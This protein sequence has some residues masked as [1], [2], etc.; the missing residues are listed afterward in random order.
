MRDYPFSHTSAFKDAAVTEADYNKLSHTKVFG[1][2]LTDL[3]NMPDRN[4]TI[5]TGFSRMSMARSLA[6]GSLR[7]LVADRQKRRSGHRAAAKH[8][9]IAPLV[10]VDG[11]RN[12]NSA[13]L[14]HMIGQFLSGIVEHELPPELGLEIGHREHP[15]AI[16]A[17]DKSAIEQLGTAAREALEQS[18]HTAEVRE[19]TP[20]PIPRVTSLLLKDAPLLSVHRKTPLFDVTPPETA[21]HVRQFDVFRRE[22]FSGFS[23][24]DAVLSATA[25]EQYVTQ[26]AVDTVEGI[27][28]GS[29]VLPI[30][31]SLIIR[32]HPT[33]TS[34]P[35][36]RDSQV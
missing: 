36:D 17:D 23:H 20:P 19:A 21:A 24:P 9:N 30:S 5:S 12:V 4:G 35:I 33:D 27:G 22:T 8:L 29:W 1:H 34:R 18:P 7:V 15:G 6:R 13:M 32:A 10:S 28:D 11:A 26:H 2:I 25:I 16:S 14:N 31:T 3:Q